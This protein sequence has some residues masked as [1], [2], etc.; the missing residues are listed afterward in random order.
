MN[1]QQAA[2][3][4]YL[5][6]SKYQMERFV[7]GQHHMPEMQYRQLLLEASGLYEALRES[8]LK[9]AK[10]EAEAEELRATGK[11]SDEIEAQIKENR[12]PSL[13]RHL[14][15][16]RRELQQLEELFERYPKY[17]LEEIEAAQE[18]YWEERLL[19][20]A[21]FQAL[22]GSLSWAQVEAI[23]QAGI[24]PEFLA[25]NPADAITEVVTPELPGGSH[26]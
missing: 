18:Q 16:T 4:T 10:A 22:T 7:I 20:T 21:H 14:L 3:E 11:K 17:T 13:E 19:R 2:T 6:R 25:M 24:L 5:N 12:I 23:W 9:I 8:E 26:D 1:L 15:T